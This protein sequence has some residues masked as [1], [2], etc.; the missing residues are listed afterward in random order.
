[1]APSLVKAKCPLTRVVV[2]VPIRRGV[3]VVCHVRLAP[4]GVGVVGDEAAGGGAA[5][6]APGN[7][8]VVN[9]AEVVGIFLLNEQAGG[10]LADPGGDIRGA[11]G[12]GPGC[13][14]AG[15][16]AAVSRE[17]FQLVVGVEAEGGR[18]SGAAPFPNL[19]SVEIEGTAGDRQIRTD[20]GGEPAGS[21]APLWEILITGHRAIGIRAGGHLIP[22]CHVNDGIRVDVP[23]LPSGKQAPE[24]IVGHDCGCRIGRAALFNQ[25]PAVIDADSLPAEGIGSCALDAQTVGGTFLR[26]LLLPISQTIERVLPCDFISREPGDLAA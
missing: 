11:D 25:E 18:S 21:G 7:V 1:M 22:G 23:G 8:V 4:G 2:G 14:V 26:D 19:V 5:G 9:G 16:S 20:D 3:G 10:F 24:G 12:D 13:A 6:D 15:D 17:G